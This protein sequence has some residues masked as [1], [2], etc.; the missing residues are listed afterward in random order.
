VLV[1][2]FGNPVKAEGRPETRTVAAASLRDRWSGYPSVGLTPT[3]LTEIFL[4]A[5]QGALQAQAELFEEM[6]EKDAHLASIMQTR[7]LAVASLEWRIE[8]AGE[9]PRELE[10]AQFVEE[11]LRATVNFQEALLDLMD[12]VGKGYSLVE[13]DWQVQEY[14]APVYL[15]WV[16]PKRVTFWQSLEPRLV[17]ETRLDG[18]PLQPWK[19]IFHR[20]KARSGHD[21]R[22]GVLRVLAWMY[23]LKNY[24]LKD[25]AAFNEIFGMPLRLGKYDSSASQADREALVTAIR[26]LGS[27][28]AGIISKN[29]EIE[30]VEAAGR[31]SGNY[32]PYQVLAEFC[33]REM[34]KAVLGQTLTTDTTYATGTY[35]A[36]KVHDR[37]RSDLIEADAEG[38]AATL[39]AQLIRPLV[40]FNFGWEE[41][42]PHFVFDYGEEEDYKATAE[43]YEILSRM[44]MPLTLEH[45]AARFNLPL[46][47]PGQ[48]IVGGVGRV[49][50]KA[51]AL[52]ALPP[53]R[54]DGPVVQAQTELEGLAQRAAAA[55]AEVVGRLLR[56]VQTLIERGDSLEQIRD[57]LLQVYPDLAVEELAE[58][59]YQASLLAYMRGRER[60]D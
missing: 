25:W 52:T 10:I 48:E 38:L 32:N 15:R 33:N 8:A 24:A 9:D 3:R 43:T 51:V 58:L 28:A 50:A 30:F 7:R 2:Q 49:A 44:G 39:R 19:F 55:S 16:H 23:L 54:W 26:A 56:P 21:T 12:A 6:E 41:P 4:A 42:L 53:T 46:P 35:S 60:R 40:G 31:L 17:D 45:V 11:R 13:I 36:A 18:K 57:E 34:S 20:H 22:A 5:D 27:D 14:A 1:D 59:I 47:E 29:T 37:V